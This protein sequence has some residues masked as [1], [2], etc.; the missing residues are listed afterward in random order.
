M[1][2]QRLNLMLH[3]SPLSCSTTD[4]PSSLGSV[5]VALQVL[6]PSEEMYT[7]TASCRALMQAE[8]SLPKFIQFGLAL[9]KI[10]W[11]EKTAPSSSGKC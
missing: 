2:P 3:M 7:T 8:G 9:R 4:S 5:S 10:L 6:L 1:P 11:G